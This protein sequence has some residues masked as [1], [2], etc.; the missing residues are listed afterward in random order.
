MLPLSMAKTGEQVMVARIGGNPDV[1]KHLEDLGFV[2]GAGVKIVSAPG[3]GNVIV[4]VK[5]ARLAITAEMAKKVMI[6]L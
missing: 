1:K 6:T 5:D 4:M 2:T 3:D